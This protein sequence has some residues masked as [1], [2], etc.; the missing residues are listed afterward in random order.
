MIDGQSLE[1]TT[2][3]ADDEGVVFDFSQR[4]EHRLG[5]HAGFGGVDLIQYDDGVHLIGQGTHGV[6]ELML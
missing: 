5:Y 4:I 6:G 2:A 3:V 1:A